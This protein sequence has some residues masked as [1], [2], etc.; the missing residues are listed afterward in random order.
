MTK[1]T[2][3]VPN[4]V[5]IV[6]LFGIMFL[7]PV[8]AFT[9]ENQGYLSDRCI[10][11]RIYPKTFLVVLLSLTLVVKS[12]I[13]L[14]NVVIV[15]GVLW[16]LLKRNE[17]SASESS[18]RKSMTKLSIRLIAIILFNFGFTLPLT[19]QTID[20]NLFRDSVCF[21]LVMSLGVFN[22]LIFFV[23]DPDIRGRICKSSAK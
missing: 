14:L 8:M 3:L 17:M 6:A 1:K 20:I 21:A 5:V 11:V 2:L 18:L 9:S 12:L 23:S 22:T 13:V 4:C 15:L 19:L 7:Y 16:S 10:A